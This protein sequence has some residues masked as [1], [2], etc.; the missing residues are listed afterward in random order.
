MPLF[1]K[2]FLFSSY[3][4]FTFTCP[5]IE[6]VFKY[7]CSEYIISLIYSDFRRDQ[8]EVKV[9]KDRFSHYPKSKCL[10]TSNA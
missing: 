8:K 1:K 9:F 3:S 4:H 5:Q 10:G 2:S 7:S 6:A